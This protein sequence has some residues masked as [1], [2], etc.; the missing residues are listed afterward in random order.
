MV[1]RDVYYINTGLETTH[2]I[3]S[4]I[5]EG[6]GGALPRLYTVKEKEAV[7]SV[8]YVVFNICNISLIF[9]D[10]CSNSIFI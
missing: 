8:T 2:E 5:C 4:E 3:G 6:L 9:C 10:L 1:K 7:Q